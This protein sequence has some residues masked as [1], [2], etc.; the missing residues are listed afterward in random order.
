MTLDTNR[1]RAACSLQ[2][3]KSHKLDCIK[4]GC[5]QVEEAGSASTHPHLT[6]SDGR[7]KNDDRSIQ[8]S[9]A[10]IPEVQCLLKR[11]PN[12]RTRLRDI[13]EAT[14]EKN[15]EQYQ[16]DQSRPTR[17][18][19]R[20]KFQQQ[21]TSRAQ[22][23]GWTTERGFEKGLERLHAS[24]EIS[25]PDQSGLGEFYKVILGLHASQRTPAVCR[26]ET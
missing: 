24:L 20:G 13:W 12:L 1:I 15:Y 7:H 22:P 9:L 23:R 17:S 21:T 25:S 8:Q 5:Q 16:R 26:D 11:Y 18:R 19:G 3:A 6:T 4:I 2:C 10:A 14:L